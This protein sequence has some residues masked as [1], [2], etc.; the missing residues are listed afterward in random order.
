M[1]RLSD[2]P[3]Y[4]E[5]ESAL[6]CCTASSSQRKYRKFVDARGKRSN[7][8]P[9]LASYIVNSSDSNFVDKYDNGT[10]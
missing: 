7:V 8:T 10:I 5:H 2:F 9:P 1:T 6:Y 4:R 3:L